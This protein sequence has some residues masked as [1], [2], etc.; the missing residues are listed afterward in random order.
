L[1]QA[2]SG[3]T[4]MVYTQQQRSY[5]CDQCGSPEVVALSLIYERGTRT[6]SGPA[7]W[8]KSQSFFALNAAPPRPKDYGWPFLFWGFLLAFISFWFWA[9]SQAF[10]KFPRAAVNVL[11]FFAL[12]GLACIAGFA[13]SCHRIR[14]HNREVFPTLQWNWLHSYRCQRCGKVVHI[15]S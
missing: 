9:F 11:V 6:Q 10:V 4:E 3:V 8:G 13:V 5:Q 14:R 2:I 15:P 7:Y 1:W 12:L